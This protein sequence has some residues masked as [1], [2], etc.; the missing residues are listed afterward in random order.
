MKHKEHSECVDRTWRQYETA[1]IRALEIKTTL[2]HK[3][4]FGCAMLETGYSWRSN[5]V[6]RKRIPRINNTVTE[7]NDHLCL[8]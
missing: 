1:L 4:N 2:Q 5:N 8:K 7:K 6:I 3:F